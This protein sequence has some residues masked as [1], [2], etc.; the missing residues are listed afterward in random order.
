M[1]KAAKAATR[2]TPATQALDRAGIAS[3]MV[4][5]AYDADAPRIGLQA[6]D[7]LG[8]EPGCILKTLMA[9]VDGRPV[10]LL[11]ASDREV[12]MKRVAAAVGEGASAVRSVH[13][14]IGVQ[15]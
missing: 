14:A 5:Y 8:V 12:S 3:V 2:A 9:A 10:C 15:A 4:A 7:A 6:A 1:V 13:T 11:I